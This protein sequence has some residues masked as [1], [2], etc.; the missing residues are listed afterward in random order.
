ML[1]SQLKKKSKLFQCKIF[2]YYGETKNNVKGIP[3]EDFKA[4][5]SGMIRIHQ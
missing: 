3:V 1:K 5:L 4:Y 2:K